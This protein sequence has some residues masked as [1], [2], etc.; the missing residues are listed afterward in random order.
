M[1]H[2]W[3]YSEEDQTLG[4]VTWLPRMDDGA[5]RSVEMGTLSGLSG[6]PAGANYMRRRRWMRKRSLL[7]PVPVAVVAPGPGDGSVLQ[8]QQQQGSSTQPALPLLSSADAAAAGGGGEAGQAGDGS[9]FDASLSPAV[10]S[11]GLLTFWKPKAK[12]GNKK[13]TGDATNGVAALASSLY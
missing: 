12:G 7:V 3:G 4:Q 5:G 9:P 1:T 8:Q 6:M 10:V 11:E 13:G 2:R